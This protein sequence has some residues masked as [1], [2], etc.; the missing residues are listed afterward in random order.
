MKWSNRFHFF[1]K[2]LLSL[3]LTVFCL[4]PLLS[5]VSLAASSASNKLWIWGANYTNQLGDGSTD[6]S[7]IP[8]QMSGL[9]EVVSIAAGDT[10][11][12]ALKSDGTVWAWG[13]NVVGELG[14]GTN[15]ESNIPVQVSGL[16]GVVAIAASSG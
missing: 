8:I 12:L 14:N 4:V 7:N 15:I 2:F 11:V 9:N 5:P 16:T 3:I 6:N 13:T 1:H 10:H